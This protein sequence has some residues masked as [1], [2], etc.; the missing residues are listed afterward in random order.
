MQKQTQPFFLKHLIIILE[1]LFQN[2]FEESGKTMEI[3][4]SIITELQ[5]VV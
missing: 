4:K 5:K 1:G 3:L 2:M